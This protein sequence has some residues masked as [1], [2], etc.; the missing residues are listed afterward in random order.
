M[1]WRFEKLGINL[2]CLTG[3]GKL[4]FVQIKEFQ[5]TEGLRS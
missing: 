3:V 2:Q 5:K 4:Q 1:I